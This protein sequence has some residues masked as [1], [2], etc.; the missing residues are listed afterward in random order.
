[1][2]VLARA[3]LERRGHEEARLEADLLVAHALGLARLELL[4]CLDRP[5]E[6]GEIDRARELLVRRGQGEPVAYITG[7]REFYARPFRVAPGVLIPRPETE[8]LVDL[9]RDHLGAR[10][11]AAPQI[12]DLGTGSGCLAITLALE[13][14]GA[15]VSAV[16]ISETALEL[17]R[18]NGRA[19]GAKVEWLHGDGLELGDERAP[20]DLV[21]ANPPYV[22]RRERASLEP[23]VRDYEPEEA[24]FAPEGDPDY[25]ARELYRRAERWLRPGGLLAVELGYDQGER[26]ASLEGV[27]LVRDLA[28]IE[29]VLCWSKPAD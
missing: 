28:G 19:L 22:D 12:L 4:L 15:E 25:W 1:M 18:E 8:L 21:V 11:G 13:L 23:Q 20:F 2:L 29:R 10:E 3:F 7:E 27:R 5:L 17:A 26:L 6:A 9:A 14:P 16:D 24:L